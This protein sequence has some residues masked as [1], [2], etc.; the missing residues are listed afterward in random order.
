MYLSLGCEY[1]W[2]IIDFY[3]THSLKPLSPEDWPGLN[4]GHHI[5][6][7]I[8]GVF[9]AEIDDIILTPISY[10]MMLHINVFGSLC[11]H[12]ID[13]HVDACLVILSEK[14]WFLELEA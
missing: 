14:N 5:S 8:A 2:Y 9:V 4:F 1:T 13:R 10:H 6:D 3:V 12:I 11:R 7:L